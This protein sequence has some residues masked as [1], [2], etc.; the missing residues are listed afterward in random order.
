MPGW[1]GSVRPAW[2]RPGAIYGADFARDRYYGGRPSCSRASDGYAETVG[3]LL[4]AFGPSVLR[5]TDRGLLVEAARTNLTIR[6]QALDHAAWLKTNV[7][8]AA[9]AAIAPDGNQTAE[10]VTAAAGISAKQLWEVAGHTATIGAVCQQAWHLKRH[11]HRY[12]Q[13]VF[14]S[15]SHGATAFANF[16]LL[17]GVVGTVG[18][19]ATAAIYLL[20]DGWFRVLVAATATLA[21]GAGSFINLT[22]SASATRSQALSAAGT[23]A[24][25]AWQPDYQVGNEITSPIATISSAATRA[26]DVVTLPRTG[27]VR[28]VCVFDDGSEQTVSGIDPSQPWSIPTNLSRPYIRE[29]YGYTT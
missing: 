18:A 24:I 19:A 13:V 12:V 22:P 2:L 9:N 20:A 28:A 25:Y 3:G 5:R 8:V 23:E 15:T 1:L 26:A 11:T 10:I 6:S 14:Y 27:I 17:D 29:L 21:G 4:L 7:S 16:D